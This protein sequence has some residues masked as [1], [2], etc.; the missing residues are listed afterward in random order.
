M[1]QVAT[2]TF[3]HPPCS[4][5]T[6]YMSLPCPRSPDPLALCFPSSRSQD[7]QDSSVSWV[8]RGVATC[9]A[10]VW[11]PLCEAVT[12]FATSVCEAVTTLATSACEAVRGVVAYVSTASPANAVLTTAA[13]LWNRLW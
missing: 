8:W 9:K 6:I 3:H 13:G 2:H 1:P 11:V 10:N 7:K 5:W 12:T 4:Y